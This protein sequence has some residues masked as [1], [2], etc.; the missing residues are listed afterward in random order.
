MTHKV[1]AMTTDSM[2]KPGGFGRRFL[3]ALLDA[4]LLSLLMYPAV[5]LL[6]SMGLAPEEF[7]P[8]SPTTRTAYFILWLIQFSAIYGYYGWFYH[9]HGAT[10]GKKMMGLK[11]LDARTG[12]H[13]SFAK[14]FF[15]E[16][17]GKWISSL[18]FGLG[19]ALIVW[20]VDGKALHDLMFY[21]RVVDVRPPMPPATPSS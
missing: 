10:P 6:Q 17:V 20:R 4:C 12:L 9:H 3:A 11:V 8:R 7:N 21:T 5:L 16:T 15:R 13:V 14:A 2:Q 1:S 19:F 18:P